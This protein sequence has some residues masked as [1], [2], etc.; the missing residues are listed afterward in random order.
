ML[1]N[2]RSKMN[3]QVSKVLLYPGP[4]TDNEN[5]V[6]KARN[7]SYNGIILRVPH[8]DFNVGDRNS[9][10]SIFECR[11]EW[12]PEIVIQITHAVDK[13]Y[14]CDKAKLIQTNEFDRA[15][16]YSGVPIWIPLRKEKST[17]LAV[18]LLKHLRDFRMIFIDIPINNRNKEDHEIIDMWKRWNTFRSNV[19]FNNKIKVNYN[20]VNCKVR[21]N[22]I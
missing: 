16:K 4:M 9:G 3:Q 10:R 8:S 19:G 1:S 6:E 7:A 15:K 22:D 5:V 12:S 14:D 17:E 2:V 18:E 21:L 13:T 11:F 20:N